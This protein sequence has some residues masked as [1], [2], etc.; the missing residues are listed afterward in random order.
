MGIKQE[1]TIDEAWNNWTMCLRGEDENSIYNQIVLMFWDTAIFRIVRESQN[2]KIN[3]NPHSPRFNRSLY[4]FIYMNYFQSQCASIRRLTDS[5]CGLR[6]KKGIF[7][8]DS[9]LKDL[10]KYREEL[11][12]VKY[13]ELRGFPYDYSEIQRKETAYLLNQYLLNQNEIIARPISEEPS[14]WKID[15]AQ[16]TFDRLSCVMPE[17]REPNDLINEHVFVCLQEKLNESENINQYVNK[18]VA[19]AATPESRSE[20]NEDDYQITIDHIWYAHQILYK[21]WNFLSCVLF[22]IETQALPLEHPTFFDFWDEPFFE[23]DEKIEKIKSILETYREETE[24]WRESSFVD[25]WLLIE[26]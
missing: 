10:I 25:M 8:L 19:H 1:V 20:F 15:D 24:V 2:V 9:I 22:S 13:L 5:S 16:K 12:R 26:S 18:F 14:W 4:S 6:G 7:S 23:K 21:V 11:S 17:N 3:Q